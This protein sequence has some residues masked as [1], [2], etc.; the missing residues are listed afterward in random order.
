VKASQLCELFV[1][2]IFHPVENQP[3]LIYRLEQVG[4]WFTP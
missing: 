4:P 1:L 2:V 3:Q